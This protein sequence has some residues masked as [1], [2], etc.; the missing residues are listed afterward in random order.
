MEPKEP[1]GSI[2]PFS[3]GE[4]L[5]PNLFWHFSHRPFAVGP[6]PSPVSPQAPHRCAA[7]VT[8]TIQMDPGAPNMIVRRFGHMNHIQVPCRLFVD[9][10]ISQHLPQG[11]LGHDPTNFAIHGA[12]EEAGLPLRLR[13]ILPHLFRFH[14]QMRLRHNCQDNRCTGG[15]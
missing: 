13:Q 10:Q 3:V 12:T 9:D 4:T 1:F 5:T 15:S 6:I 7:E 11:P 2:Y 8:D 14:H